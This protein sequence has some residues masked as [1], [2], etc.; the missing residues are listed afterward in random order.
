MSVNIN[1]VVEGQGKKID[2]IL[3]RAKETSSVTE[4]SNQ[5]LTKLKERTGRVSVCYRFIVYLSLAA[6]T[7]FLMHLLLIN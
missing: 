5:L 2:H 7:L 3:K 6:F 1:Q 4:K